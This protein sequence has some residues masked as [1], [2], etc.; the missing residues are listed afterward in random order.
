M[1]T[2]SKRCDKRHLSHRIKLWWIPSI[3]EGS[4]F[5]TREVGQ[6]NLCLLRNQ[7]TPTSEELCSM[8]CATKVVGFKHQVL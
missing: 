3:E 8:L 7:S 5:S 1:L 2:V 6:A 4:N